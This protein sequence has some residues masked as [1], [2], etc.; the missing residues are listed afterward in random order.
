MDCSMNDN[1]GERLIEK[2]HK[3]EKISMPNTIYEL[4]EKWIL[5][6]KHKHKWKQ[7]TECQENI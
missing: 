5:W 3:A 7:S 1:S 2:L 6:E 4:A